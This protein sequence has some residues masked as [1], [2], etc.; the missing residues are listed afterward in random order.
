ML[1]E[2]DPIICFTFRCQTVPKF[3]TNSRPG[4]IHYLKKKKKKL[5]FEY[6][7]MA[8]SNVDQLYMSAPLLSCHWGGGANAG[9]IQYIILSCAF[10]DNLILAA[11]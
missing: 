8:S 3:A 2:F 4:E 5:T 7:I 6:V 9:K 11:C 1:S 10:K